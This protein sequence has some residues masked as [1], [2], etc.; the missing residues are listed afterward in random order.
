VTYDDAGVVDGITCAFNRFNGI[1]FNNE[2]PETTIR[3]AS[4]IQNLRTPG[5][6][7]GLLTLP[8]DPI[9]HALPNQF[10][11]KTPHI[12]LTEKLKGVSPL[13]EWALLHEICHFPQWSEALTTANDTE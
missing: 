2:L 10:R 11:L 6:P 7:V 4:S 5:T 1:V 3:W 12:F 9:T 8:D 13:D